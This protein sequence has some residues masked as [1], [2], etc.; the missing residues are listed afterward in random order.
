MA[1]LQSER[2]LACSIILIKLKLALP[3]AAT[4]TIAVLFLI[5]AGDGLATYFTPDD[6]MNLYGAWFRPLAEQDR[7]LGALVYRCVFAGFGLDPLPYRILC[8]ALLSLNLV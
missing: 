8:F 6:M 7:P 5:F 2:Q 4:L 3:I 1:N